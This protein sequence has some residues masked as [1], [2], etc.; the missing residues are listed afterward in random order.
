[1]AWVKIHTEIL[2]DDKL[3]RA[4]RKGAT[5]LLLVPW[6]MV[7][8]KAAD[9]GGRLTVGGEPA[10]PEDIADKCPGATAADVTAC[11]EELTRFTKS[12]IRRDRD[13]AYRF[14]NWVKRQEKPSDS[15]ESVRER[16]TRHRAKKRASNVTKFTSIA[17]EIVQTTPRIP[18]LTV[19]TQP[20]SLQDVTPSNA[21]E[22][23]GEE[24]GEGEAEGEENRELRSV[25]IATGAPHGAADVDKTHE[26]EEIAEPNTRKSPLGQL[27]GAVRKVWWQPDGEPPT[28]WSIERELGAWKRL[29]HQD[30]DRCIQAIHGAQMLKQQGRTW[31]HNDP[32]DVADLTWMES[33]KLTARIFINASAGVVPI[34]ALA[35]DAYNR[36]PPAEPAKS[37]SRRRESRT[38]PESLTKLLPVGHGR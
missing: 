20:T 13:G 27:A 25:A 18:G 11:L 32:R 30:V 21:T 28:G 3:M 31:W 9:D 12:L 16:V 19:S 38:G 24:E 37:K 5:H 10:D 36:G 7:F 29:G 6:L 17:A 26:A 4:A 35:L 23:E 14:L 8:A 22:V 2:G 33:E 1:M 34:W 15:R